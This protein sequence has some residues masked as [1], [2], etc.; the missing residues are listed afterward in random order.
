MAASKFLF[1]TSFDSDDRRSPAPQVPCEPEP[2][3]EEPAAPPEPT[4]SAAELAAARSEGE[5]QGRAVALQEAL[6]S[7]EHAVTKSLEQ[8][9]LQ[10]EG[11]L[12][13]LK[14]VTEEHRVQCLRLSLAVLR[15]LFP[16]LSE[17]HGLSEIER[18]I[19]DALGRLQEEP[20][21]VVRVADGL[22]DALNKRIDPVAQRAGFEGKIVLI[23]DEDLSPG[24]VRVEWA[25][26]GAEREP[27]SNWSDIEAMI[28]AAIPDAHEPPGPTENPAPPTKA[29][30]TDP[31][32]PEPAPQTAP[33]LNPEGLQSPPAE[34]LVSQA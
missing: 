8:L 5:A 26:G 2:V 32:Q 17:N 22:L 24:A 19:A 11:L 12:R 16:R 29:P 20:R 13:G 14:V 25:D 34:E 27:E 1:D 9:G 31:Q 7:D 4:F 21:I 30:E 3:V 23:A 18:V 28:D 10:M 33:P 15:K 6:A